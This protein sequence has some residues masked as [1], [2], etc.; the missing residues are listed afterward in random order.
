MAALVQFTCRPGKCNV[1]L[2]SQG[3][4]AASTLQNLY[5]SLL[6]LAPPT[7]SGEIVFLVEFRVDS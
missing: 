7:T 6:K 4:A 5:E 2:A 1:K 3:E